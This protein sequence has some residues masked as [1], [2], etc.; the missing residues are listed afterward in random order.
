MNGNFRAA[1]SWD[2]SNAGALKLQLEPGI[3]SIDLKTLG[4]QKFSGLRDRIEGQLSLKARLRGESAS[5]EDLPKS[6]DGQGEAQVKNGSIRNFNLVQLL[7]S[8]VSTLPGFSRLRFPTRFAALAQRKDTAFD[9]LTGTYTVKQGRIYSKDLLLAT[10]DY[11]ISADGSIGLDKTVKFNAV[12]V[13]SPQFTQELVQEYKNVRYLVDRRGRLALP[14]QVEG[15]LPRIQARPDLQK[16]GQQAQKD[17]GIKGTERAP[18]EAEKPA[19]KSRRERIQKG[20]ERFFG[21]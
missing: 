6:L 9:S 11:N 15:R 4:L 8:K 18:E 13:L 10:A 3:E 1:G 20:V 16:L 19:K 21:K 12:L 14:F 5:L 17:A 7:F 2:T